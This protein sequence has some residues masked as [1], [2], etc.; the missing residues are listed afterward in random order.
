MRGLKYMIDNKA[1]KSKKDKDDDQELIRPAFM[2]K[3]K[4]EEFNEEELEIYKFYVKKEEEIKEKNDKIRS[5][6]LTKLD[7][8]K[9]KIKSLK[10]DLDAKFLKIYKKKL[11][12][13]YR[14]CEQT[15]YILA[16]QR[17]LESR[18]D[19]KN[20]VFDLK[21]RIKEKQSKEEMLKKEYNSFE[22]AYFIFIS[23]YKEIEKLYYERNKSNK[24]LEN[25]E[26]T[27][28]ENLELTQSE[29]EQLLKIR[30]D[31]FY[32]S[33]REKFRNQKKYGA[34]SYKELKMVGKQSA[35]ENIQVINYK[36]YVIYV[37]I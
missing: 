26:K 27:L 3:K 1:L 16:L 24:A 23:K 20:T 14:I 30:T 18:E 19:L 25:F 10:A 2:D 15:I 31:P 32:F 5:Q 11:Y 37:Y 7:N 34:K 33:E 22:E 8:H 12:Y 13:D 29:K 35:D 36:Y 6:N 4:R 17:T 28:L 9:T 21:E